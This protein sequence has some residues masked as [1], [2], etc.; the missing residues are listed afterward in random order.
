M[1]S[2]SRW[3]I[4]LTVFFCIYGSFHLYFLIKMRRAFYLESWSYILLLVLLVYL[5]LAPIQARILG[6][7][8]YPLFSLLLTWVGYIWMGYLF[9]FICLSIPLDLY[10]LIAS[11]LQHLRNADYTDFMLS[12]RQNA[13]LVASLAAVLMIY[14]AYAAYNVR[15]EQITLRSPKITAAAGRVRIVQ[16]SDLHLGPMIYP[17]RLG[18]VLDAIAASKPDILISTGDLIDGNFKDS[19]SIA[20]LFK[21]LPAQ[22]GKFAITGNHEFYAGIQH[23]L[24]ATHAAG[25]R[26]LRGESMPVGQD[27]VIAGVD[28][29]AGGP[30]PGN[31]EGGLLAALPENRFRIL[32][33]HRPVVEAAGGKHFDLQLS[34]H[35]HRGQ[36][37]PFNFLVGLFYPMDDGLYEL[38][39]GGYLY[40]SR[41]TGTWGPPVRVLSPP[42]VT[43]IDLLPEQ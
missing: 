27:V 7:E 40:T 30:S 43:V 29:P 38:A 13:V 41:G 1:G 26:M 32:L 5:M 9:L 8:G 17:G 14:G 16:I 35:A 42:E 23:S 22:L 6:S 33:K 25:F 28:D 31:S 36:I 21:A 3:I 2:L 39:G 24:A 18:P 37:F 12:R 15:I 20:Q 11:S 4:F 10:H 19:D 34:G